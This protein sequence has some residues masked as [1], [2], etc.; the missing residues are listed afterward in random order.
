[1]VSLKFLNNNMIND[2]KSFSLFVRELLENLGGEGFGELSFSFEIYFI[3][4]KNLNEQ[5]DK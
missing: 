3:F 2:Y 4:L 1:M 5:H